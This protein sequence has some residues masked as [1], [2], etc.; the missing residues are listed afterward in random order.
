MVEKVNV[1]YG[2][3]A[4]CILP[5]LYA[6][7]GTLAFLLRFYE[8]QSTKRVLIAGAKHR[9]L[10]AG[11][12][13]LIVGQFNNLTQT[14]SISPFAISFLAGYAVDV[15]FDFWEACCKCSSANRIPIIP[16]EV[17]AGPGIEPGTQGFFSPLR[18]T[19]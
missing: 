19:N 9:L 11:I 17:V 13:G 12:V 16:E 6:L 14:I 4:T 7:L 15:Y 1:Y 3:I 5:V 8:D 10:T 2:A 18:S